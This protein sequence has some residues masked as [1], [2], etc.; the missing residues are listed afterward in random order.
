MTG[1]RSIDSHVCA[2][3]FILGDER[4]CTFHGLYDIC[5]MVKLASLKRLAGSRVIRVKLPNVDHCNSAPCKG[6]DRMQQSAHIA[7][8]E[9]VRLSRHHLF[10]H[11]EI[12]A[13]L[14]RCATTMC[15]C[16]C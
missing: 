14:C 12:R 1:C 4:S 2:A 6:G 8:Q 16:C 3:N 5:A 7:T 9:D 11:S 10:P 15:C 13:L